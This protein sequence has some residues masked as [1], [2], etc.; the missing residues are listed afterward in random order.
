MITKRTFLVSLL[1][2]LIG[3]GALRQH[4][5]SSPPSVPEAV[6]VTQPPSQQAVSATQPQTP[7]TAPSQAIAAQPQPSYAA[8]SPTIDVAIEVAVQG[9]GKPF[10]VGKTN[11]PDGFEAIAAMNEGTQVLGQAKIE[12]HSGQFTAGPFTMQGFAY[13]GGIYTFTVDSPFTELQPSNVQAAIGPKG[14]FLRGPW[15]K[16]D[17]G[18]RFVA[19]RTRVEIPSQA[20]KTSTAAAQP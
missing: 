14:A 2:A 8:P 6:Q 13:P 20:A 18:H 11:L 12:V 19:F 3:V 7:Y 4:G 10:I 17:E 5:S 9:G 16:L 1:V 15:V